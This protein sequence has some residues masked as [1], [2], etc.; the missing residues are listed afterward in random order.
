MVSHRTKTTSGT[1]TLT[2]ATN[3]Y[4]KIGNTVRLDCFIHQ[5]DVTGINGSVRL[6]GLPFTVSGYAPIAVTYCNLFSFN[7]ATD[8][9][10]GFVESGASYV[11]LTLGSSSVAIPST[12]A[13]ETSGTMMFTVVYKTNA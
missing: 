9:V 8:T 5:A 7:E 2:V 1:A 12:D 6:A 3:S 10:G 13:N 11:N 4:T